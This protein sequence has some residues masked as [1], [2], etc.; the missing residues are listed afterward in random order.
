MNHSKLIASPAHSKNCK[1]S[2]L[3]FRTEY[4]FKV[5]NFKTFAI[6]LAVLSLIAGGCKNPDNDYKNPETKDEQK[7]EDKKTLVGALSPFNDHQYAEL[8]TCA[9][10]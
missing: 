2:Q 9:N 1:K 3:Y 10:E 8:K 7:K 5:P 6:T 4:K